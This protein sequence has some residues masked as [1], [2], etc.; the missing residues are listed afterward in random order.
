[1]K[2]IWGIF[3]LFCIVIVVLGR[4]YYNQKKLNT[5]LSYINEQITNKQ[6][7]SF[8]HEQY[9]DYERKINGLKIDTGTKILDYKGNCLVLNTV[10]T[11]YDSIFVLYSK[12]CENNR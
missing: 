7:N 9:R 5:Q 6:V 3:I 11:N 1:M 10:F 12:K 2:Y 4:L 8:A